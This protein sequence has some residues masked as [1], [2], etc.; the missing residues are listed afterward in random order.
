MT[1]DFKYFTK[2]EYFPHIQDLKIQGVFFEGEKLHTGSNQRGTFQVDNWQCLRAN[3]GKKVKN[4]EITLKNFQ[5]ELC[6]D[7][8]QS[9]WRFFTA[10]ST[11][12]KALKLF[13][14]L[15]EFDK[16]MK[17]I[18]KI[19]TRTGSSAITGRLKTLEDYIVKNEN[20]QGDFENN[21][22]EFTT[23]EQT[24]LNE[25][26]KTFE[27]T[28]KEAKKILKQG[29]KSD[30]AKKVLST[31]V[32]KQLIPPYHKEHE[33]QFD[34]TLKLIGISPK[35][36]L[37]ATP[38]DNSIQAVLDVFSIRDDDKGVVLYAPSYFYS[39]LIGKLFFKSKIKHLV[40]SAPA[41]EDETE[42]ETAALLW[43]PDSDN[44]CLYSAVEMGEMI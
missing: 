17:N 35:P 16:D 20:L 34:E 22:T 10:A 5:K 8:A 31:N 13:I 3:E 2:T 11:R 19:T 33:F 9:R 27:G 12:N 30:S 6:L 23:K 41:P 28:V 37:G 15:A 38:N 25:R 21:L 4:G 36:V 18:I 40:L 14:E 42:R 29:L 32:K 44:R 1:I 26:F 43:N 24:L 7:C 39:Y